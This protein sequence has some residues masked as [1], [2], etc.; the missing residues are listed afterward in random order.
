MRLQEKDGYCTRRQAKA[1]PEGEAPAQWPTK[2]TAADYTRETG[3]G[4]HEDHS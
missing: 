2:E 3:S 4:Y 1:E